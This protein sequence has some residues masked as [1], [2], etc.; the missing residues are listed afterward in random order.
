MNP[1]K[2]PLVIS[3]LVLA[4]IYSV[5]LPG[6]IRAADVIS[7]QEWQITAD[8]IIRYATPPC[9]IAEGNVILEKVQTIT[10]DGKI[11]GKTDWSSLLGESA[12]ATRPGS[13]ELR[14]EKVTVTTVRA[15]WLVYDMDL[16]TVKARGE[17]LIRIGPDQLTATQGVINL[18]RETGIFTDAT[19]IRQDKELH[20]AG[21]VIEK[22]GVLTYHIED[23]WIITCRLKDGQTPPWSFAAVDATI[24]DNGYAVL[25]HATFRIKGVPVLYTPYM[26]LPAKRRRQTG[27]L[28]PRASQS[29]RDGFGLELPFFINLS[30]SSDLTLYPYYMA[31]RGLMNGLEFRYVLDQDSKGEFRLNFLNDA[32]SDPK[33]PDNA[34]YYRDGNYTHTNENRYWLR[35]KLDHDFA[36]WVT[37]LDLDLVS[38]RDYLTEFNSGITGFNSTNDR[39]LE[40]FG[41]G[42]QN[43]DD[44][45]RKNSFRVLRSWANGISF[46]GELLGIN[47]VREDTSAPTPLWKLPAFSLT[48]LSPVRDT[49]INLT[50]NVD[51]VNYW[52]EEGVGA[53][54][55]DLFP[56]LSMPVPLN[57][58]LETTVELGL[59]NTSYLVREHGGTTWTRDDFQNRFLFE[60]SAETGTTMVRDFPM[61]IGGI[62]TLSHTFRPYIMYGYIP[63]VDQEDLPRFDIVDS[64][65][66]KNLVTYGLDNYFRIAG[67]REGRSYQRQYGYLKLSQGYDLR[68]SESD[69]P[70]TPLSLKLGYRPLGDLSLLYKSDLDMYGDGFVMH[71]LEGSYRDSRGDTVAVDYRYKKLEKINSI[72][73]KTRLNLFN[74]VSAGYSIERSL[75]DRKT[76]EEN[77]MLIYQPACWSVELASNYTP[78]NQKFTLMF[79]LANIGGPLGLGW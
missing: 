41:R 1:D 42:F 51:Y 63:D 45:Q 10:R 50:W 68:S 2:S 66:E 60:F 22:T 58:Y 69:T 49:S 36:Q 31:D 32:R 14:T 25:K 38:D 59:R 37:R 46:Q 21:R 48:G 8:R 67:T 53:Q 77:A 64:I 23:G 76:V 7:A 78:G 15:D 11:S 61:R 74:H 12:P 39:F 73:F 6:S 18:K 40:V 19:I 72:T 3:A 33:D 56:R 34:E 4:L 70:L 47:D 13:A 16:G 35:G 26:V 79:R 52:R 29:S 20:L 54:R 30:P 62:H 17:L 28:L 57:R 44:D 43:G 71:G 9:V 55:I 65:G 5:L 75:E 24:E 27:F